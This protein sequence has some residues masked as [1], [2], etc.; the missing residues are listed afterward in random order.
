[1]SKQVY[2]VDPENADLWRWD[3]A[4]WAKIIDAPGLPGWISDSDDPNYRSSKGTVFV[5]AGQLWLRYHNDTTD[6]VTVV[7][8]ADLDATPTYD[9]S[10]PITIEQGAEHEIWGSPINYCGAV[11]WLAWIEGTSR[12]QIYRFDGSS[13]TRSVITA[14]GGAWTDLWDI[15]PGASQHQGGGLLV[16]HDDRLLWG[17]QGTLGHP[18]TVGLDRVMKLD[19][20]SHSVSAQVVP[21]WLGGS[22]GLASLENPW[23]TG[24]DTSPSLPGLKAAMAVGSHRGRLY[25]LRMDGVL[26]RVDDFSLLPTPCHDLRADSG[27]NMQTLAVQAPVSPWAHFRTTPDHL[28]VGSNWSKNFKFARVHVLSGPMAGLVASVSAM[29]TAGGGT[30]WGLVNEDG[31]ALDAPLA[32]GTTVS[33][34][35]GW[36]GPLSDDPGAFPPGPVGSAAIISDDTH[37]YV[38]VA[39]TNGVSANSNL[40][41][42]AP[43]V[44]FKWTGVLPTDPGYDPTTDTPVQGYISDHGV[45]VNACGLDLAADPAAGMLHASWGDIKALAVKHCRINMGSLLPSPP[46]VVF[47]LKDS[48]FP[49]AVKPGGLTAYGLYEPSPVVN[50]TT[51]RP[52]SRTVR[53]DF[54]IFTTSPTPLTAVSVLIEYNDGAEWRPA[55]PLIG[56]PDFNLPVPAGASQDGEGYTFVHDLATDGVGTTSLQYRITASL[57]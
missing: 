43:M 45:L 51:F 16:A 8:V 39:T 33:I 49:C 7:P 30:D 19:P 20:K 17:P 18:S 14:V 55:T 40:D 23:S 13:L 38:V 31:A 37:L 22:T 42:H 46:E 29:D 47:A 6:L 2:L 54:S 4:S 34:N 5:F 50:G 25:W 41:T 44:V 3:G 10:D 56:D 57:E 24:A 53:L 27:L 28:T 36:G 52:V 26:C 12:P 21:A 9:L 35:Y 1:M 32:A 48:D 11:V 15:A